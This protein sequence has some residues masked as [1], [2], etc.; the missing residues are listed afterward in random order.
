MNQYHTPI[1][2]YERCTL[3]GN[4]VD[5][6]PENSLTLA[7]HGPIF[8]TPITC[9]YCTICEDICP[10]GAIRAPFQFLWES[11]E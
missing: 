5:L 10:E 2:N 8:K 9:T 11:K 4:C 1:I 3:C 7:E 6:C